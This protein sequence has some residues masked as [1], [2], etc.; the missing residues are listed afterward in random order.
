LKFKLTMMVL[1]LSA[2]TL[3]SQYFYDSYTDGQKL[4]TA[5]AYLLVSEQFMKLGDTE[6]AAKYKEMALFIYP[7]LI[8]TDREELEVQVSVPEKIE[9]QEITGP[10]KSKEIKYYFSKLL[11]SVTTEDLETADSLVAQRLYLPEYNGGL[12][13]EQLLPMVREIDRM[14]NL[15]TF[16]PADLYRLETISVEKVEEGT[17]NLTIAG[18]DNDSLYTAGI[19]FFGRVQKFRFRNFDSGW[20]VDKISIV[21]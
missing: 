16:A 1:L 17:Y 10:D 19:T 4:D 21:R 15:S 12:T 8:L 18:A 9:K 5:H 2:M 11:R 20:K 14:Y 3:N 6:Q 13:K 7:E